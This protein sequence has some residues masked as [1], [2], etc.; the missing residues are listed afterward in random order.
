MRAKGRV[1]VADAVVL[2]GGKADWGKLLDIQMMVVVPGKERTK[3]EF[4]A[5]FKQAGL[6]LAR[7]IPTSC[8]LSVIE[9]VRA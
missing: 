6:K 1:L 4:A 7:V 5:L 8:P 2:P 9:A 3:E